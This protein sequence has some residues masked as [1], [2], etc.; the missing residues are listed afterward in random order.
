LLREGAEWIELVPHLRKLA[1][2]P[3]MDQEASIKTFLKKSRKGK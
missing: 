2:L 1:G 3:A